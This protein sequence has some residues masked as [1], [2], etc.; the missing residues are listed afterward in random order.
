MANQIPVGYEEYYN[1][2]IT[3]NTF[4]NPDYR[5]HSQYTENYMTMEGFQFDEYPGEKIREASEAFKR[6]EEGKKLSLTPLKK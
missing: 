3:S 6:Y 5:T 4:V 1:P 2:Y